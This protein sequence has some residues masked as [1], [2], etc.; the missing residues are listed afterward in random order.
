MSAP[1]K[2]MLVAVEASADTLGAGLARALRAR[3]GVDG[4]AFVGVGGA[5]MA[6]EGIE[7][8]F[9]IGELSLVGLFEIAGAVPLALRRL[10]DTVRLAE[11]EQPD[12]AVLIDSWEFMWRVARRLKLR[13]PSALRVKLVAPQVWATRPGRVRTSARLFDLMLTLFDFEPPYFEAVGLRTISVGNPALRRDISGAQ[14]ARLRAAIGAGPD[15]PIL[16]VLPGSRPSEIKRVMPAFEDAVNRL[17]AERPQLHV[18]V[19]AADTVAGQVASRVA[20]WPHRAHVVQ[21]E[22]DKLDA[23]RAA[24]LAIACSGTV[25]T[26]LAVAGCPMI[27][28]YRGHPLTALVARIIIRTRFFTLVN[29]AAGAEIAPEFLQERCNGAEI[30]AA[31]GA[32]LDDPARRAGQTAAQTAALT[33]LGV[34]DRDPYAAAAGAIVDLVR[35]GRIG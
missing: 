5:R 17:K 13:V 26:E 28:G 27:V 10:E 29:I 6:S 34:G 21:G 24:T 8:P 11:A 23:M 14:P 33:K 30:A 20:G 4:V 22:R 9:D 18:V 3:L 19:G 1:L 25:T 15:D 16:L 7:S 31:A 2:V 32:L 12:V 35:E